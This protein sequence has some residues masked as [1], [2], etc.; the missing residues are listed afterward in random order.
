M[1]A[2]TE[3]YRIL[4]ANLPVLLKRLSKIPDPRN[5]E[6]AE[7]RRANKDTISVK[8]YLSRRFTQMYADRVKYKKSPALFLV[9]IKKISV[10]PRKSACPV[11]FTIVRS[12]AYL[13]GAAKKINSVAK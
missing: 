5:P 6:D 12:A 11:K 2:V 4:Q 9:F 1:T 7:R 8:R 3:Q 10:N 13:T